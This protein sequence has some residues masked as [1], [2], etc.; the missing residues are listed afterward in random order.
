MRTL[1]NSGWHWVVL[2]AVAA[3]LMIAATPLPTFKPMAQTRTFK[4]QAR[5]F[6][7]A[8]STLRV[9]SGDR[10]TIELTSLDYVH[11]LYIDGY[12]LNL[13]SDPGQ[14]SRITFVADEV[15]TFRL[16]CSVTCG[17][18]HPFMIG[19]LVVGDGYLWLRAAGLSVLAAVVGLWRGRR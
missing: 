8:P 17:A 7:Y 16:R 11:G 2:A 19:K 5:S 18:M 3:A 13:V 9:Q 1:L 14:T 10:V 15:G 12:D 4:I 6:A